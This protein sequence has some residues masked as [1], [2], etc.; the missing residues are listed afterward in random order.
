MTSDEEH[1]NSDG[2][3]FVIDKSLMIS[4]KSLKLH[5]SIDSGCVKEVGEYTFIDLSAAMRTSRGL[6][7]VLTCR[8][9]MNKTDDKRTIIRKSGILKKVRNARDL[10][11]RAAIAHSVKSSKAAERVLKF[12][13]GG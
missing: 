1:A 6:A 10:A 9:R 3:E 4:C 5:A 11:V 8:L 12:R 13:T 7:R 2:D